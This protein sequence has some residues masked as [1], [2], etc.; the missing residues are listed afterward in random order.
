MVARVLKKIKGESSVGAGQQ[1]QASKCVGIERKCTDQQ[2]EGQ[3]QWLSESELQP[4]L[5][6]KRA[7]DVRAGGAPSVEVAPGGTV[8]RPG[9]V[10]EVEDSGRDLGRP[11]GRRKVMGTGS[12]V[13]CAQRER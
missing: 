12:T 4:W 8:G 2:N 5:L 9:V 6:A 3:S 1:E 13:E 10:A 7:Q 11:H